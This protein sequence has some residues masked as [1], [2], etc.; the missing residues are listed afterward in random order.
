MLLEFM[1]MGKRLQMVM[2]NKQIYDMKNKIYDTYKAAGVNNMS[3]E[4][5]YNIIPGG[6]AK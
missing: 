6:K 4:E 1:H 3:T 2:K 5:V